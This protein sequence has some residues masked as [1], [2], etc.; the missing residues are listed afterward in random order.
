[1]FRKECGK[2]GSGRRL[3]PPF[4]R[5]PQ[6]IFPAS[7]HPGPSPHP[8]G[9]PEHGR[10]VH[11]CTLFCP[12]YSLCLGWPSP[13]PHSFKTQFQSHAP[14]SPEG[15]L[16]CGLHCGRSNIVISV[17]VLSAS[18]GKG[19]LSY[20]KKKCLCYPHTTGPLST[21][22]VS[23]L[24]TFCA[25]CCAWCSLQAWRKVT[26][27]LPFLSPSPVTFLQNDWN[28]QPDWLSNFSFIKSLFCCFVIEL[29]AALK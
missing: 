10:S 20:R 15:D 11:A 4:V 2:S 24:L 12:H 28:I 7:S 16:Q 26:D 13:L 19:L 27:P 25:G 8:V 17:M 6:L 21:G 29:P 18:Q 1:M 9:L 23:I 5:R 14:H 3:E 22:T